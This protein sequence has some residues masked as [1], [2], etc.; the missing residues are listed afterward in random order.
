MAAHE[1]KRDPGSFRQLSRPVRPLTQEIHD[2]PAVR[3]RQRGESAIEVTGAH[4]SGLNLNPVA[5]SMSSTETVL[6]A[7]AK[8]Q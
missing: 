7:C 3:V 8:V 2:A 4:V 5:C 6:P 1:R